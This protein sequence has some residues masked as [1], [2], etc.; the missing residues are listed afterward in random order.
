MP[1]KEKLTEDL[2]KALLRA[3]AVGL[4]A[5]RL[6]AGLFKM[7]LSILAMFLICHFSGEA[8]TGFILTLLL[9]AGFCAMAGHKLIRN[10]ILASGFVAAALAV[11]SPVFIAVGSIS[12]SV[13]GNRVGAYA[14]WG[15]IF[16]AGIILGFLSLVAGKAYS[17]ESGRPQ[18]EV[19]VLLGI[20][21]ILVF[22][23]LFGTI[24]AN[25]TDGR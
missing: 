12:S 2:A 24:P 22:V 7:G 21:F 1:E 13:F 14:F 6:E 17:D 4:K 18:E 3:S 15:V 8:K 20:G 23:I 25:L 9:G 19:Y 5:E 16:Y 11:S 10:G